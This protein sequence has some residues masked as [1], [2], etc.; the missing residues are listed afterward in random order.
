MVGWVGNVFCP[1]I[2]YGLVHGQLVVKN[3]YMVGWVGYWHTQ[4][5]RRS[6]PPKFADRPKHPKNP[7][8]QNRLKTQKAKIS[9]IPECPVTSQNTQKSIFDKKRKFSKS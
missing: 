7:K 3:P 9:R 8:K 2:G 5:Q 4:A 1:K 6:L